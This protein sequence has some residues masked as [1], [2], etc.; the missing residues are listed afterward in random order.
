MKLKRF[1]LRYYPPGIILEYE[2]QNVI[3]TKSIDLLDLKA[4]TNVEQVVEEIAK[5]EP[6][7]TSSRKDQV[8]QLVQRLQQ[9]IAQPDDRYFY[10]FKVLRAHILPLTN[11][12]FNKSGS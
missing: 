1:L 4:D 10:L 6:L 7:I 3:K 5:K 12:S 9:K 8:S 11:V 2:Q